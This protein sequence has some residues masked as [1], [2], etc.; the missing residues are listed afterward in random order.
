LSS[1]HKL[2]TAGVALLLPLV[3]SAESLV[4]EPPEPAK[5]YNEKTLC[6]KPVEDMRRNHMKYI[7]HQRDETVHQG[8]R[9]KQFSLKEC[10]D[11]HNAPSPKDGK[12][13]SIE[14][15]KH[16]CSTC[17]NYAA[18]SI[19]CFECHSDKPQNTQYRHPISEHKV[20]QHQ[21]GAN[22]NL[23][24]QTLEKLAAKEDR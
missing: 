7:L 12:V 17:H 16:F 2:I 18:V 21:F 22:Q 8:I 11:C 14:S 1:M 20:P 15:N 4:P 9:T 3:V 13:A 24:P 5:K 10:I 6:V 23:S 19:D